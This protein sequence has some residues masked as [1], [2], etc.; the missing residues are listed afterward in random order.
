MTRASISGSPMPASPGTAMC[1]IGR[2]PSRCSLLYAKEVPYRDGAPLGDTVFANTIAAYEALPDAIDTPARRAEGGCIAIRCGG[3]SPTASRP[4][5]TAA[6]LAEHARC[7]ATRLC[8]RTL[9]TG[10]KALYITAGE[11]IGIDG[12]PD[13]EALEVDR[14]V[15]RALRAAPSF[16]IVTNGRSATW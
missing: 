10:R 3:A 7:V 5:L 2:K 11:C 9:I 1:R 4:T 15:G 6:Q 14:R 13:D 12:M 8:G 16:A